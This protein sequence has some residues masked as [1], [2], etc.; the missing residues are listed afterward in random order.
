MM[1]HDNSASAIVTLAKL[2]NFNGDPVIQAESWK[3]AKIVVNQHTYGGI[4]NIAGAAWSS[5]LTDTCDCT[6]QRLYSF[7]A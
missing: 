3:E 4:L 2:I 7:E 5:A 1:A 6:G